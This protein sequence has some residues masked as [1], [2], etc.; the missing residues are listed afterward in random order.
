MDER[1]E[2]KRKRKKQR[3]NIQNPFHAKFVIVLVYSCNSQ[4]LLVPSTHL[5]LSLLLTQWQEVHSIFPN[6]S[7]LAGVGP[8]GSQRFSKDS[9]FTWCLL[10]R[11]KNSAGDMPVSQMPH[12]ASLMLHPATRSPYTTSAHPSGVL[13]SNSTTLSQLHWSGIQQTLYKHWLSTGTVL[14]TSMQNLIGFGVYTS[15]RKTDIKTDKQPCWKN[16]MISLRG[17]LQRWV[18]K[19]ERELVN[20]SSKRELYFKTRKRHV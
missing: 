11:E 15:G 8:R 12:L 19:Q 7:D 20:W 17:R 14:D 13:N 5:H 18:L 3:K 10:L 2:W 4:G 6:S 16:Q 1:E 9:K